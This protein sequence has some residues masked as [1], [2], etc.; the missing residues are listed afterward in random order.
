MEGQILQPSVVC[1][2]PC[3]YGNISL[4][5]QRSSLGF[6]FEQALMGLGKGSPHPTVQGWAQGRGRTPL[7]HSYPQQEIPLPVAGD[8]KTWTGLSRCLFP[9]SSGVFL[10]CLPKALLHPSWAPADPPRGS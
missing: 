7:P 10:I 6:S 3:S 8:L 2:C 5:Q 4:Q 1:Y 9:Y